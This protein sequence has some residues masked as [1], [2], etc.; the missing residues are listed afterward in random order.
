MPSTAAA[1]SESRSAD[2]PDSEDDKADIGVPDEVS[3]AADAAAPAPYLFGL[4]MSYESGGSLQETLF[5]RRSGGAS[6]PATMLDRLRVLKEVATGLYH[7][8]AVNLVHGDL[9][10]EN[11]LLASGTDLRVRLADFGLATLRASADRAS[12]IS[13]LATTDS[14]RGTYSYMAPEMFAS[15]TARAAAALR[16][17]RL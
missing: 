11:V 15:R 7:L 3:A 12:R 8:H 2:G 1:A 14:K 13:T 5:P 6:W 10:L 16:I 4:I 17:N 9:K